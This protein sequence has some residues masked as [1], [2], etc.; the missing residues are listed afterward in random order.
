MKNKFK[1]NIILH[2]GLHKAA[3]SFFQYHLNLIKK[4]SHKIFLNKSILVKLTLNYLKNPDD[5]LKEEILNIIKQEKCKSVLLSAE[6]LLGHQYYGFNS[7]KRF[8][9]LEELFNRPNY[10][11]F[12]RE[13]SSIIY[14]GY[15]QGIQKSHSLEFENYID[16]NRHDR[17]NANFRN[18][19]TRG[20]DYKIFDYN[21]ILKDYVK[22]QNRVLFI[23]HEYFF[24]AKKID[25][26]KKF[27]NI[28]FKFNWNLKVNYSMQKLKYLEIYQKKISFRL[29]KFFILLLRKKFKTKK[30]ARE[31]SRETEI[32]IDRI[33]QNQ[34]NKDLKELDNKHSS[35]L[36]KIKKYH[37]KNYSI[38]KNNLRS[39][40]HI[41]SN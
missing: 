13:P 17:K 25:K 30:K 23:E 5:K 38:F 10:I 7:S 16:K 24:K 18:L 3:S 8:K 40:L 19:W 37:S 41:I 27:T 22:I 14:S 35:L 20:L 6:G 2:I 12:F 36:K 9:L 15:F 26:L 29:I 4:Q 34:K 39:D 21:K 28:N 11:I 32:I 33:I 1:K 31:L